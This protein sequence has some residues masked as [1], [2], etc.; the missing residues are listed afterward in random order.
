M[1][2]GDIAGKSVITKLIYYSYR[3]AHYIIKQIVR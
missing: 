3:Q 1:V 2:K